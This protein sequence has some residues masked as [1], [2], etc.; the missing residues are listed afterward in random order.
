[1]KLI[2]T[3]VHCLT[4]DSTL[5]SLCVVCP[6][7]SVFISNC[8]DYL[9]VRLPCSAVNDYTKQKKTR[10]KKT[11]NNLQINMKK[12]FLNSSSPRQSL[13]KIIF[14]I[15]IYTHTHSTHQ[16]H[17]VLLKYIIRFTVLLHLTYICESIIIT[18]I[19]FKINVK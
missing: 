17:T 6:T 18:I 8:D 7:D 2:C 4:L 9:L 10:I 15:Y 13:D 12:G 11:S 19:I 5:Q 3:I 1:M 16:N 14:Y